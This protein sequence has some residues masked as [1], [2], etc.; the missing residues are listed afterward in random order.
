MSQVSLQHRSRQLILL[1]LDQ[2]DYSGRSLR[3]EL[4]FYGEVMTAASFY[5]HMY[6]LEKDNL[7][8]GWYETR[9]IDDQ[10][11]HE[12]WYRITPLGKLSCDLANFTLPGPAERLS[13]AVVRR[14]LWRLNM[15][16]VLVGVGVV[17]F[18]VGTMM[19]VGGLGWWWLRQVWR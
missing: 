16:E 15:M 8:E 9:T 13:G 18:L 7:V 19:V 6:Q 2:Q 5:Y 1:L 4:C 17:A 3:F 10:V 12:R 11:I 14:L